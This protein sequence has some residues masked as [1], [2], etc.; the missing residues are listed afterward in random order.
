MESVP[1][2]YLIRLNE[3][4]TEAFEFTLN[5]KTFDLIAQPVPDPPDWATLGHMQCPHCPLEEKTTPHCPLALQLHDIVGRFH[6]TTSIDEVEVEVVTG[7]RRVIQVLAL[8]EAIA[9]MLDLIWPICGCPKTTHMK[10]LARFH[11]PM[12]TEEETVFRVTGMYL[13]A[14]YFL[15]QISDEA[16]IEFDGLNK[17]YEEFHE[18]NTAVARR[19]RGATQ[20]DS[21]KNAVTL[22]DMYSMLVPTLLDDQLVEMR[23]FFHSY[24]PK[25]FKEVAK[26]NHLQKAKAFRM[27]LSPLDGTFEAAKGGEDDEERKEKTI[28]EILSRS[29]L[30]LELVPMEEKKEEEEEEE[31]KAEEPLMPHQEKPGETKI[32]IHK[33]KAPPRHRSF[34][35]KPGS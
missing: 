32:V 5:G 3:E 28:E 16:R 34:F 1:I 12:A 21:V 7:Q 33:G 2:K 11:L 25:G 6:D 9:S 13:L 31:E 8:Q 35:R 17:I 27:E 19:L 15:S 26:T 22:I 14:K 30:Q 24:L 10:V 18:L 4:R 23:S 20:S 29:G